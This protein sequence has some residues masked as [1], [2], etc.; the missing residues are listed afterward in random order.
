VTR[1]ETWV[2]DPYAVYAREILKL[3]PLDPP[4]MAMDARARGTAV[5]R[6]FQTLGERYGATPQG[7]AAGLFEAE[8]IRALEAAGV[9]ETA[10]AR[11]RALARRLAGWAADF[12]AERGSDGRRLLIEQEGLLRLVVHGQPF[13]LTAKADR[14]EVQDGLAHVLDF[15]TGGAPTR[16]QIE[17]GFSP[18]LT[19]TAAILMGG[20]FEGVPPMDPGD[21]LYVRVTG[22]RVAGEVCLALAAADSREE[23]ERALAG[24]KAQ[25]ARFRDPDQPYRSWAAAQFISDR[26]IGDYDHL[27]RVF[28]WHVTGVEEGDA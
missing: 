15:K 8:L 14:I 20:G 12:E 17:Q 13:T 2:R 22:R 1:I 19:L 18:Q 28:E 4:D 25:V 5:H 16:K 3:R 6:A 26:G 21:L 7:E 10:M 9:S 23:A 27:A 11:E 24:L